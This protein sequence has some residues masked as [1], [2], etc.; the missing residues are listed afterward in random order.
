MGVRMRKIGFSSGALAKGD[1]R[2]GCALQRGH[3]RIGAVELSALRESEL[4][5]F[6]Y[7]VASL[8]LSGFSYVSV[9]APSKLREFSEKEVVD[10]LVTLPSAWPIVVHPDIVHDF[11]CWARLG[12]RLCLENMDVRKRTGQTAADLAVFFDQLPEA[13]FCFDVGHAHQVDPTMSIAAE[14]L[15]SFSDRLLQLHVS[16]VGV[17]GEHRP[18]GYL[19]VSAFRRIQKL[20]PKT[21]PM[22]LEGVIHPDELEEELDRSYC[23]LGSEVDDEMEL[24]LA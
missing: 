7:G 11:D 12:D 10:L 14:L 3:R 19:L 16:D 20:I 23:L 2:R 8:D 4:E 6:V 18:I 13:G 1:F 24:E 17:Y 15:R 5:P 9:H 22:I 21:T